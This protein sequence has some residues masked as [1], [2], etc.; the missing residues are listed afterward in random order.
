LTRKPVV[1]GCDLAGERFA[2]VIIPT[3]LKQKLNALIAPREKD[4]SV[5]VPESENIS[6]L[7]QVVMRSDLLLLAGE[8]VLSKEIAS[9]ALV[10]LWVSGLNGHGSITPLWRIL[11]KM[12]SMLR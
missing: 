9:G 11:A 3:E 1:E 6:L 10:P 5:A 7:A 8:Q 2:S 4:G 12:T